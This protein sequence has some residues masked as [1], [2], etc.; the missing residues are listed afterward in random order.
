MAYN[1]GNTGQVSMALILNDWCP[2]EKKKQEELLSLCK[3]PENKATCSHSD[4]Q[5]LYKSRRAVSPKTS[6]N[7]TLILDF[8]VPEQCKSNFLLFKPRSVWYFV[9]AA[10]AH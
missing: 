6:C 1:E 3:Y 5:A 9:V 2:Y 10:L 4:K 8:Q 7:G